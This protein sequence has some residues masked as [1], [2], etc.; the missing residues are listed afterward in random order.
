MTKFETRGVEF[1]QNSTTPSEA[2]RNFAYSCDI[3]CK[4]G[5]KIDCDRCGIAV[6][7]KLIMALFADKEVKS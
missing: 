3:C 2:Q 1:Q 7:N 6:C 4:R 5:I